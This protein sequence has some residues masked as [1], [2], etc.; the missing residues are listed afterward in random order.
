MIMRISA[1][2]LTLLCAGPLPAAA[3][4]A[5]TVQACVARRVELAKQAEAYQG[6]P[7]IKA[8]IE[9]DIQRAAAEAAEG[10]ARE[11]TEALDHAVKLLAGKY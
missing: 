5:D 4:A 6:D 11:C 1:L 9:A 2:I 10:D 7:Q 8:L 3:A